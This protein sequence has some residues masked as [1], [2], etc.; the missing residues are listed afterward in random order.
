MR[1]TLVLTFLL[2]AALALSIAFGETPLSLTQYGDALRR[3]ASPVR[4]ILF[5]IRAPRG[6]CAA[7]VG[8]ALGMAGA[9]MQGLLRNPLAAP[10]LFGAP[11]SAAF[12]AVLVI[13]LGLADVRSWALP[14]VA[15]MAA[16]TSVFALLAIAV[17]SLISFRCAGSNRCRSR[18]HL[19]CRGKGRGGK[20]AARA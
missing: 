12:G 11:Q 10:S 20:P 15:I 8:G 13:A 1:V 2:L 18:S 5:G 19:G 6:C 4:E 17:D 14:V 3:P 9:V 16:F 7:L